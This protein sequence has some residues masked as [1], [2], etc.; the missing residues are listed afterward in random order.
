MSRTLTR[1]A[2][3]AAGV[4]LLI[5]VLAMHALTGPYSAASALTADSMPRTSATTHYAV[6]AHAVPAAVSATDESM[7]G[8]APC[9]AILRGHQH[10]PSSG[11]PGGVC[12]LLDA[13]DPA[14]AR[15]APPLLSMRASPP[16]LLTRLC[17]SRT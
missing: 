12:A 11:Q 7:C 9:V 6:T 3:V 5:G 1:L 2:R 15:D 16:G 4:V 14:G 8:H 10:S 17:I 13:V